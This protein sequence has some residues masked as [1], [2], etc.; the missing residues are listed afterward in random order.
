MA[1]SSVPYSNHK[2]IMTY[3]KIQKSILQRI[4]GVWAI[5]HRS[6]ARGLCCDNSV[7]MC[8][9]KPPGNKGINKF[10]RNARGTSGISE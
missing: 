6:Q 2:I 4:E 10:P 7:Y 1:K 5:H 3:L 9:T 8:I